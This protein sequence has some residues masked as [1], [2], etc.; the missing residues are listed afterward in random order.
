MI[1]ASLG[2]RVSHKTLGTSKGLLFCDIE[3]VCGL[4]V[5]EAVTVTR[6]FVED[7]GW[8]GSLDTTWITLVDSLT[9]WFWLLVVVVVVVMVFVVE[10]LRRIEGGLIRWEGGKPLDLSPRPGGLRGLGP[11][12]GL[13]GNLSLWGLGKD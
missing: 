4:E 5:C 13:N 12:L 3:E 1:E 7:R 8:E 11:P 9:G 2:S 10:R 6:G